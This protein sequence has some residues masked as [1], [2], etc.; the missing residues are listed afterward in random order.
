[1]S[2]ST[3]QKNIFLIWFG[4]NIPPYV[5][6][7]VN[8]YKKI[9][10]DFNVVFIHKPF[11][12]IQNNINLNINYQQN[13]FEKILQYGFNILKNIYNAVY[14]YYEY[15]NI[16]ILFSD[17]IRLLLLNIY[18]GIYVDCDTF[19]IRK[20]DDQ[21]LSYN[22]FNV[23]SYTYA[24]KLIDDNFFIGK[25]KFYNTIN[26]QQFIKRRK[27]NIETKKILQSHQQYTNSIQFLIYKKMFFS[28]DNTLY[29]K[30]ANDKKLNNFYIQHFNAT[31][32][33]KHTRC[34]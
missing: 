26:I 19:P 12:Y 15:H 14:K 8:M 16:Y 10:S 24:N 32:A 34:I 22:A 18:G 1:M 30:L 29:Q 27:I 2:N 9:N 33:F 23:V 21:L 13:E 5:L 3:I 20:F 17:I 11:N 25:N 31:N 7:S 28:C 6:F 4:N